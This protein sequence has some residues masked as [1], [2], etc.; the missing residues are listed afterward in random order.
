MSYQ[1]RREVSVNRLD[2]ELVFS[3]TYRSLTLLLPSRSLFSKW[4]RDAYF[5]V[6]FIEAILIAASGA[7]LVMVT[8]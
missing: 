7:S 2:L 3:P 1:V 4:Q 6:I 5:Y 8:V